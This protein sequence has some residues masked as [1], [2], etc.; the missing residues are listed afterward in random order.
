MDNQPVP[1]ATILL[2]R[3]MPAFEVL[4]IERH[5]DLGFAGGALVF[6]GG[7]I[8]PGDHDPRW[9]RCADGLDP[10]LAPAQIAA[11]REAFEETGVLLAREGAALID[12]PRAAGLASWRPLVAADD[13]KFLEMI[14]GQGLRLA[15][16]GLRLFAH[17]VASPRLRRRFDT[18]FFA[19][20]CPADHA[21]LAD[22]SEATEALWIAPHNAIEARR[23]RAR[24][25]IFPT[26]RNLELLGVSGSVDE[27]FAFA[28][29]RPIP[30]ITADIETRDGVDWLVLPTGLGYPVTEEIVDPAMRG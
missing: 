6:P 15:C 26:A 24:K 7:R 1:A 9:A 4:M 23:S 2:L 19:A 8:D 13:G 28:A 5:A 27:V 3:D 10:R 25:V 30:A 12:G 11:V 18:L 20:R 16:D 21:A 22:G 14:A 29:R 17:W